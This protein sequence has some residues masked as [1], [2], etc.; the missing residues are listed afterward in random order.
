MLLRV[1][2]I[3]LGSIRP[4][5]GR[6]GRSRSVVA[7]FL[8]I[9]SRLPVSNPNQA[10]EWSSSRRATRRDLPTKEAVFDPVMTLETVVSRPIAAFGLSSYRLE[11]RL[12]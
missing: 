8:Q 11:R 9:Q 3:P 12:D 6:L 5:E 2:A 7:N 4:Q 10:T 1:E